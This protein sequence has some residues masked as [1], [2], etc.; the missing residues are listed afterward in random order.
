MRSA[1]R[2]SLIR[3]SLG[4]FTL[5]LFCA[6][7]SFVVAQ[8]VAALSGEVT[9][10]TGALVPDVAVKLVDTKTNATYE[11]ASNS[12]GAYVFT[13]V[14]P[15]P[16]YQITFTKKGFNT[17]TVSDVYLGVNTTHTQNAQLTVGTTTTTIEV[18]AQGT[19]VS[20]NT[21]DASV[22]NNFDL[23]MVHELPVQVRE[24]PAQMLRFQPG[25]I[26]A[27]NSG[28]TDNSNQSRDGS[29]SGARTDQANI[30]V[31]GLDVNDFATGQAFYTTVNAPIDSVQEFRGEVANPLS[32][33]G[34]GS[35]GQIALV[36]KSGSNNWHGSASEYYRT[37]GFEADDF[38]NNFAV[39]AVGRA[40]LVRNQFGASFG[41]PVIKDKLFFFFDYA[42][43]RDA[44]SNKVT[45]VVPTASFASGVITYETAGGAGTNTQS[46]AQTKAL[47]PSLI[48]VD[49]ALT[50][51][52]QGRYPAPNST[53]VGDGLNT[54]GYQFNSPGNQT[55]ND[56]ITRIDY[57]LNAKQKLFV[58][59]SLQRETD[60]RNPSIQF[61]GD[62]LTFVDINHSWAYVFGH[63]WAI[64]STKVNQFI[65]GE[66]KQEFNFPYLYK[67]LGTTVF[68]FD[69]NPSGGGNFSG[70]YMTPASQ[71]RTIPIPVFRD[72]FT[73]VRGNHTFQVGGNFKP[74]KSTSLLISDFNYATLG[75]GGGLLSLNSSPQLRP[76]DL[77]TPANDPVNGTYYTGLY[78]SAFTFLLGHF[79]EVSS[80]FNN[81]A[82]L[83]PI[84]QGSGHIRNYRYYETEAY[85]QD[86]WKARSDLT[87]TYGLRYQFYSVPY[88][89][90]GLEALP[91]L[92]F[93]QVIGPRIANGAEGL[94]GPLLNPFITYSLGGK[95]NHARG[96]YSADWHD[97]QPRLA[98]AY[99]LG[100]HKTVIRGGA[101][102]V[103]DH[104]SIDALNFLQDQNTWILQNQTATVYGTSGTAA[105]KLTGDQRLT[106]INA[107][108]AG[109][110]QIPGQITTPYTPNVSGGVPYGLVDGID[111]Y[112]IDPNL[113]T[114]YSET[115]T[116]GIQHELPGNFQLDASYVGRFAHRLLAQS[117][118]L[119]A[120]DFLDI[121]SGTHLA[122]QF[123][124]LSLAVRNNQSINNPNDFPFFENQMNIAAQ[125]TYG[126][127]CEDFGF[128]SCASLAAA[129]AGT[130]VPYG[131]LSDTVYALNA[132]GLITPGV[133]LNPQF[134]T[135]LYMTNKGFSK[136]N[137][138][139]VTLHKKMS[140]GLQFDLNYTWSHSLDNISAPA[141][142]AFGSNG[143]GG[144]LCDSINIH[145]CYGNSD[146]DVTNAFNGDLLYALPVGRGKAFG[147]TMSKWA[148]EIVGGWQISSLMSWRTG[149]AF[150]TVANAYPISFANNVPAIFDGNTSALQIHTHSE[151]NAASGNPTIQLFKNQANA[152]GSFSG[153]LGLEA[154]S[155][156]NLRGPH[157]SNFDIGLSKN[158]PITERAHMEFR[159]D[160]FNAFNHANFALPG[161]NATADITSPT[162][163]GVI[164]STTG[165]QPYRVLQLALRLDF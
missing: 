60:D 124:K 164:S 132:T 121:P 24:T 59:G 155:R 122:S 87:V 41:G 149:L 6:L 99:S 11:T 154:G 96:L 137:G 89:I 73:Y 30:T 111:N 163:F 102:I 148:D 97:F 80:V 61:P 25:V 7:P 157:Y 68:T 123:A 105:Q 146:F 37:K 152:L 47:D 29:I 94:S 38:F 135:S 63:T 23:S 57:N 62:P 8:D 2:L 76:L 55:L 118:A 43:R 45:R 65:Y 153:P 113:K 28:T 3:A 106:A 74:I 156:N 103:D 82:Q 159:A 115:Y 16:G 27:Q 131:D 147:A 158:F 127:T 79:A 14:A 109:S 91:N 49:T 48:G 143:A 130:Y 81:N 107:L 54:A 75:L 88:E 33:E 50:T 70:P 35:G 93:D 17:V 42:G 72:D 116:F 40:N 36:T 136:Y 31:D 39:P 69:G 20:L 160:A 84:P 52:L 98:F 86:S 1:I 32:T 138:L 92:D 151:I 134:G 108:P 21:N 128:P 125:A 51:F 58:R 133:G 90:H 44:T 144:I 85:I 83:T 150:Q 126:A 77:D 9:D 18:N 101:A 64:S 67:P 104:T 140:R 13:R 145:V 15:G 4:L 165:E 12:V 117:D 142:Q 112:A 5:A 56:Y 120:V 19:A 66:T 139:L 46:L 71:D 110:V 114:P 26:S 34:R 129:V 141:N 53:A 22:G 162:S 95:A 78:D 100:D 161:A 119:Q 10:T